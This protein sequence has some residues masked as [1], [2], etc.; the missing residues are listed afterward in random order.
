VQIWDQ[1]S[2]D[3]SASTEYGRLIVPPGTDDSHVIRGETLEHLADAIDARL[4]SLAVK[5]GGVR[6]AEGF[7]PTLR[8]TVNRFNELA[9]SGRYYIRSSAGRG[10]P[11]RR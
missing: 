2:Q 6:L 10:S 9:A 3:H 5:T 7:L 11:R 4:A 8:A 1:R